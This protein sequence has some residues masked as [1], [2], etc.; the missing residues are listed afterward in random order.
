MIFSTTPFCVMPS[1]SAVN[2]LSK[3]VA[4]PLY[5]NVERTSTL[6]AHSITKS[7]RNSVE[8]PQRDV[9]KCRHRSIVSALQSS[10]FETDVMAHES[11]SPPTAQERPAR[12]ESIIAA[13]GSS[14]RSLTAAKRFDAA[15]AL[16]SP[17]PFQP[18]SVTLLAHP[19]PRA[20]NALS[21]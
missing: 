6:V 20:S 9:W 3:A 10:E 14:G 12:L 5:E 19:E 18:S 7:R 11:E 13:R 17:Q 1:A 4:A 8:P 21:M 15:I 2:S 16:L